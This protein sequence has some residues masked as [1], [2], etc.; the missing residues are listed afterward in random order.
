MFSP[1]PWTDYSIAVAALLAVYY[2]LFAFKFYSGQIKAA[3]ISG[4]TNWWRLPRGEP[5]GMVEGL[6]THEVGFEMPADN[7]LAPQAPV[8]QETVAFEQ[9]VGLG[10]QLTTLIDEANQQNYDAT[11]LSL[12]LQMVLQ[13]Y[14][15]VHEKAFRI[16]I[17][18]FIDNQCA[19][20][21]SVHLSERDKAAIW[22]QV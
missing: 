13:D 17:N 22:D 14:P 15:L 11:E 2:I 1:T 10:N 19:K 20:Y 16:S 18:E 21:G 7:A 9:I 5:A 6:A 3:V 4:G 8:L 12:L